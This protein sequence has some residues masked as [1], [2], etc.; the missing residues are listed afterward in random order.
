MVNSCDFSVMRGLQYTNCRALHSWWN[1]M[2]LMTS[3]GLAGSPSVHTGEDLRKLRLLS[4]TIENMDSPEHS[5]SLVSRLAFLAKSI[6]CGQTG[7]CLLRETP[8]YL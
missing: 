1:S 5:F 4:S 2:L 7:K 3:V 6:C 8:K